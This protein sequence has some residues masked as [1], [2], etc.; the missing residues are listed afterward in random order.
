MNHRDP[1]VSWFAQK[2]NLLADG[3]FLP[4][5]AA[6]EISDAD[7]PAFLKDNKLIELQQDHDALAQLEPTI[8]VETWLGC[9]DSRDNR[10]TIWR[11]G[12]EMASLLIRCEYQDLLDL[13]F[14]HELGHWFH[15]KAETANGETWNPSALQNATKEYLEAWAQWFAWLYAK[16]HGELLC[17]VFEDLEKTQSNPYKAWREAFGVGEF[18]TEDQRKYLRSLAY[19][20]REQSSLRLDHIKFEGLDLSE[21][22]KGSWRGIVPNL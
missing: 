21:D 9:Y 18:S 19:L 16:E 2:Q 6:I 1:Y 13:V 8:D 5:L 12:V 11:R 3:K 7:P 15:D 4:R 14:V 22:V 20:R 10:I 17:K